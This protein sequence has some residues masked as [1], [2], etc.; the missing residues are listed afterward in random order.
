MSENP[1]LPKAEWGCVPNMRFLTNPRKEPRYFAM[2]EVPCG[3]INVEDRLPELHDDGIDKCSDYVLIFVPDIDDPRCPKSERFCHCTIAQ[4]GD[5][6]QGPKW[7]ELGCD[8]MPN[9][10]HWMPL[11]EAPNV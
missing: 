9:P 2:A 3:W 7:Y 5:Y 4:C 10:S 6:G 8:H 1:E 11:P